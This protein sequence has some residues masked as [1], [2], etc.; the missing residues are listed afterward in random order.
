MNHSRSQISVE[1]AAGKLGA[2]EP[3]QDDAD[4]FQLLKIPHTSNKGLLSDIPQITV[5]AKAVF[6]HCRFLD[7]LQDSSRKP[8]SITKG[9]LASKTTAAIESNCT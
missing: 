2:H 4:I 3:L 9:S 6:F 7:Q 8:Q 1:Q 5:G